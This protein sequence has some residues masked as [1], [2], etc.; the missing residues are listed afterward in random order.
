[1]RW[2]KV[3]VALV[4]SLSGALGSVDAQN[5]SRR[6]P[7]QNR[8]TPTPSCSRTAHARRRSRGGEELAPTRGLGLS[9]FRTRALWSWEPS[10]KPPSGTGLTEIARA[11]GVCA[12]HAVHS[13]HGAS[14]H[15]AMSRATRKPSPRAILVD[16]LVDRNYEVF[17]GEQRPRVLA[18][19]SGTQDREPRL[20]CCRRYLG[21]DRATSAPD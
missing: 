10:R 7:D 1:M 3:M 15:V 12:V 16:V 2:L 19:G 14:H 13:A 21:L 17:K 8:A 20:P 9:P 11:L 5:L 4:A 6:G 18:P